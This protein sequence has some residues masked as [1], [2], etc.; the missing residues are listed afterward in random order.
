MREQDEEDAESS[1]GGGMMPHP[2]R[3]AEVSHGVS[4][5]SSSLSNGYHHAQHQ[6]HHQQYAQDG[7]G[8]SGAGG[9]PKG[10]RVQEVNTASSPK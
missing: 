1:E 7:G 6:Q 3:V 4:S 8:G 2:L 10:F 5:V 9:S